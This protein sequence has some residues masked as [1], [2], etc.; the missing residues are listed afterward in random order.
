MTSS[1]RAPS[2]LSAHSRAPSVDDDTSRLSVLRA[3]LQGLRFVDD[4]L[5]QGAAAGHRREGPDG[6]QRRAGARGSE[7]RRSS[8]DQGSLRPA[9]RRS[10]LASASM[11]SLA[12]ENV[13]YEEGSGDGTYDVSPIGVGLDVTRRDAENGMDAATNAETHVKTASSALLSQS[14]KDELKMLREL[15]KSLEKEKYELSARHARSLTLLESK[16]AVIDQLEKE[17]DALLEEKERLSRTLSQASANL[18]RSQAQVADL[19]DVGEELRDELRGAEEDH[20]DVVVRLEERLMHREMALEEERKAREELEGNMDEVSAAMDAAEELMLEMERRCAGLEET[21]QGLARF[22]RVRLGVDDEAVRTVMRAGGFGAFGSLGE[23][24]GPGSAVATGGGRG[25]AQTT[26]TAAGSEDTDDADDYPTSHAVLL[27]ANKALEDALIRHAVPTTKVAVSVGDNVEEVALPV[28]ATEEA[29]EIA[30]LREQLHVAQQVA[31]QAETELMMSRKGSHD[32]LDMSQG[33]DGRD[34]RRNGAIEQE[35]RRELEEEAQR[36]RDDALNKIVEL[37]ESLEA[38]R[39]SLKTSEA[40]NMELESLLETALGNKDAT[41]ADMARSNKGA[42]EVFGQMQKEIQSLRADLYA[43]QRSLSSKEAKIA[44]L[45]ATQQ[46]SL[47]I[48]DWDTLDVDSIDPS[49]APIEFLV[50]SLQEAAQMQGEL[51]ESLSEHA[52]EREQG[53]HAL[54]ALERDLERAIGVL[55]PLGGGSARYAYEAA[56]EKSASSFSERLGEMDR[57]EAETLRAQVEKSVAIQQGQAEAFSLLAKKIRDK[58]AELKAKVKGYESMIRE[59]E[60][61]F[62]DL[63]TAVPA[64]RSSLAKLALVE[65]GE[66]AAVEILSSGSSTHGV[67]SGPCRG[68]IVELSISVA[69]KLSGIAQAMSEGSLGKLRDANNDPQSLADLRSLEARLKEVEAQ[70]EAAKAEARQATTALLELKGQ[71]QARS[72]PPNSPMSVG[73]SATSGAILGDDLLG[74][75]TRFE[76]LLEESG[77][78]ED[79]IRALEDEN[80]MLIRRG[81][82]TECDDQNLD[83]EL[84]RARLEIAAL[85]SANRQQVEHMEALRLELEGA[86]ASLESALRKQNLMS[87]RHIEDLSQ[88]KD[89]YEGQIGQLKFA[90]EADRAHLIELVDRATGERGQLQDTLD[91]A[92]ANISNLEKRLCA[93]EEERQAMERFLKGQIRRTDAIDAEAALQQAKEERDKRVV[94]ERKLETMIQHHNGLFESTGGDKREALDDETMGERLRDAQARIDDIERRLVPG[95]ESIK[96]NWGAVDDELAHLE[97]EVVNMI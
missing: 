1:L 38:A 90:A 72:P 78:L 24:G 17:K 87:E 37:E 74:F 83:E 21:C 60:A 61:F 33:S 96:A 41:E 14:L 6:G 75:V 18:T 30:R 71:L 29:Q 43:T 16:D 2:R 46:F 34:K 11:S 13:S 68:D 64:V 47:D 51:L 67:Q 36:W 8:F 69:E 65:E 89:A 97:N 9:L 49:S 10:S 62:A 73:V 93:V 19:L 55:D 81:S 66:A 26:S 31:L 82:S 53:R 28:F 3:S 94:L 52:F 15:Q 88:L 63:E 95:Q 56:V 58:E 12:T 76:E 45:Q 35:G 40:K 4:D 32:P 70:Y 27:Q 5:G 44:S 84:A 86:H 20:D 22:V 59:H 23:S 39:S 57:E 91:E 85:Q 79:R 48:S 92:E 50:R 80:A 25:A 42:K 7:S 77:R 54:V